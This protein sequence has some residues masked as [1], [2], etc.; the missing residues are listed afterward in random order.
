MTANVL[1][2]SVIPLGTLLGGLAIQR[3]GSISLVYTVI[4]VL[5]FCIPLV[6]SFTALGHAERYLPRTDEDALARRADSRAVS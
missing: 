1:G 2:G 6:F 4:G 5:V 3:I